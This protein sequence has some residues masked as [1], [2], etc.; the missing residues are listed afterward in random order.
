MLTAINWESTVAIWLCGEIKMKINKKS[1]ALSKAVTLDKLMTFSSPRHNVKS[2]RF[3]PRSCIGS[4]SYIS[5]VQDL[6]LGVHDLG[7]HSTW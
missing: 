6:C 4:V 5:P 3:I 7:T 2:R 1:E